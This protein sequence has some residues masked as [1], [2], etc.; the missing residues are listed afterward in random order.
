MRNTKRTKRR[1]FSSAE[2][3]NFAR[4]LRKLAGVDR[5]SGENLLE[6]FTLLQRIFPKLRLKVVPDN[7]ILRGDAQ[8]YPESWIIKIRQGI[9]DGLLRG[10]AEAR[11]TFAHE[12]GHVVLRHAGRPFR[13]RLADEDHA[14][15]EAHIFAAEFLAPSD[16]V[17][18]QAKLS[19]SSDFASTSKLVDD[20]RKR[21]RISSDAT[22]RRISEIQHIPPDRQARMLEDHAAIICEAISTSIAE[23]PGA[24]PVEPFRN[25][26][27]CSSLIVAKGADL[28]LDAYDSA[29]PS[30]QTDCTIRAA[31][32]AAS[33]LAIRPIREIGNQT[34]EA[35]GQVRRL[36]QLCAIVAAGRIFQFEPLDSTSLPDT[37][38]VASLAFPSDY[39]R[40]L[41]SLSEQMVAN[42]S[43]IVHP[44]QLPSYFEYN[45]G[46]D[47]SWT[48]LNALEE[49]ASFL[50]LM[51]AALNS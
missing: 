19:P 1:T 25:N 12:L 3:A 38:S 7:A 27:F 26:L 10:D 41:I 23:R 40:S 16:L 32:I 14:E 8:A 33:I 49:I 37:T 43:T 47:V 13:D 34:I 15:R 5:R 22:R 30:K 4:L 50:R 31:A 39:L 17:V 36:N 48:E 2:I 51:K 45:A 42:S 24:L 29:F 9:L 20:L 28:L 18:A 35:E 11:W 6:T 46:V 21:F 44:F